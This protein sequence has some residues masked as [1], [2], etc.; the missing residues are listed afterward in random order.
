M[1][2][3]FEK[4]LCQRQSIATTILQSAVERQRLANAYLLIGREIADKW[5]IARQL[6]C[7]L[8]CL[9]RAD[10]KLDC[11]SKVD[12]TGTKSGS[13]CQNCRWIADDK[14][15]QAWL[16]LA[17]DESSKTGKLAV[18][19]AR[20][21]LEE[22]SKTSQY[23]R[24]VVVPDAAQENFHRPAAN[25]LLKTIEEPGPSCLFL[26]F[27]TQMEDVLPTILSRCQ[28]IPVLQSAGSATADVSPN[29]ALTNEIKINFDIRKATLSDALGWSAGLLEIAQQGIEPKLIIDI[30]V[31]SEIE[32]LRGAAADDSA[33]ALYLSRLLQLAEASK[34]QMEH[35]VQPRFALES[36]AIA[37]QE[38]GSVRRH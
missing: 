5:L 38:L 28:V 8:N 37:W 9:E 29:E 4:S 18:E 15:P 10:G 12:G 30:V 26:L 11:Q 19:K 7:Y 1:S 33:I 34:L 32:R 22:L 3:L 16:I 20:L 17:A 27:A 36:F 35:F 6:S 21:L 2:G 25:A 23:I 13:L 14:H 31:S 24:T